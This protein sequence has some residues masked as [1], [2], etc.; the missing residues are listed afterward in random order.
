M[1]HFGSLVKRLRLERELGLREFCFQVRIDPSNFSKME[2]GKIDPPEPDSTTFRLICDAL[3]VNAS[4]E[5]AKELA[6]LASVG[7]GRI[8]EGVLGKEQIAGMLPAF[9]RT[10]D[11]GPISDEERQELIRVIQEA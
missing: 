6:R 2:R 3:D 10:L 5:E 1:E 9:F 4:S 7:R 8:P 11:G